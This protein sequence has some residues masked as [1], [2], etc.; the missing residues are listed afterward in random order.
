MGV[1]VGS[2]VG[3]FVATNMVGAM[4]ALGDAVAVGILVG[5]GSLVTV[6]VGLFVGTLVVVIAEGLV[7][8]GVLVIVGVGVFVTVG[9]RDAVGVVFEGVGVPVSVAVGLTL[10]VGVNVFVGVRVSSET[11]WF[12]AG[13][14]IVGVLRVTMLNIAGGI[15]SAPKNIPKR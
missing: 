2:D 1:V 10:N 9:V 8:V 14:W 13:F 15:M 4:V 11:C 6:G 5:V 12:S 7:G 3:V